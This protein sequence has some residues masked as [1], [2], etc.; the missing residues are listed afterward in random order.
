MHYKSS[1]TK[2]ILRYHMKPTYHRYKYPGPILH[3]TDVSIHTLDL[4]VYIESAK[5][6]FVVEQNFW[7]VAV[8]EINSDNLE[9]RNW[10][11]VPH[12]KNA[13]KS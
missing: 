8:G 12:I 13:N 7:I 10:E 2:P 1:K 3:I 6:G 11:L 4:P 9:T 5:V